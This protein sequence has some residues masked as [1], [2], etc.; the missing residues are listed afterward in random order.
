M[1]PINRS[2]RAVTHDSKVITGRRLNRD[3]SSSTPPSAFSH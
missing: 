2:V 3:T 1:L